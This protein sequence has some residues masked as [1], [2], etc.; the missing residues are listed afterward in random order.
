MNF[1]IALSLQ[2]EVSEMDHHLRLGYLAT[3][4]IWTACSKLNPSFNGVS[5]WVNAGQQHECSDDWSLAE[6][7]LSTLGWHH[8]AERHD[9]TTSLLRGQMN[10]VNAE[11]EE[12]SCFRLGK[13][14]LFFTS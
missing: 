13:E 6:W 4:T 10:E 5:D 1:A 8:P 2:E 14:N 9:M 7:L 11:R 12:L 3:S